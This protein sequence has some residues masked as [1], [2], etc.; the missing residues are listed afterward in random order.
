MKFEVRALRLETSYFR[1]PC[2]PV[3]NERQTVGG[4][5]PFPIELAGQKLIPFA[6]YPAQQAMCSA[7]FGRFFHAAEQYNSDGS[8]AYLLLSRWT[9]LFVLRP[10]G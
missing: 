4:P 5:A 9:L 7:M 6:K 1:L 3:W 8:A 10:A 2:V